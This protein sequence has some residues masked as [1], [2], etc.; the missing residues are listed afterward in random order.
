[1]LQF[2]SRKNY[3]LRMF[4][5]IVKLL[6]RKS[7]QPEIG[8]SC[9][10]VIVP[11]N[12]NG[13]NTNHCNVPPLPLS[14]LPLRTPRPTDRTHK[15]FFFNLGSVKK[16]RIFM[17]EEKKS[18]FWIR[19]II[20]NV[21]AIKSAIVIARKSNFFLFNSSSTFTTFYLLYCFILLFYTYSFSS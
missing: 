8:G 11:G 17:R 4:Q 21:I 18:S 3:Q 16:P 1:M 10:S 5:K 2:Y 15:Q 9:G 13:R 7:E 19:R 12:G 14:S 6:F 20:Q